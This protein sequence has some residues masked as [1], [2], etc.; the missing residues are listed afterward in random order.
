MNIDEFLRT[1]N[2]RLAA[3]PPDAIEEALVGAA[4]WSTFVFRAL[5]DAAADHGMV[6]CAAR[7]IT[8]STDVGAWTKREYLFD[9]TWFLRT[10]ADWDTPALILEHENLWNREAFMADFWKLLIGYAPLRVMMAYAGDSEARESWIAHV[11]EVLSHRE[12]AI[13]LPDD[14]D[15]LILLG[16]RGMKPTG[17]AVYRRQGRRFE[18]MSDSLDSV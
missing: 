17:Y 10:C 2:A 9:V 18:R 5:A 1:L 4:N 11:N 7:H 12:A 8:A 16:H 6:S 14:V 13:R 15:D 3:A